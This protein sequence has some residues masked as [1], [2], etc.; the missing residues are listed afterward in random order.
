MQLLIGAFLGC[1]VGAGVWIVCGY[2]NA[3]YQPEPVSAPAEDNASP[4]RRQKGLAAPRAVLLQAAFAVLG[5]YLWW[6][7]SNP[8][9]V[10]AALVLTGLLACIS[11]VDFQVRRIPNALCLALVG[12]ALVQML[13]LGQPRPAS[14]ALGMLIAGVL[15]FV[16]AL[17]GRG[18][19]GAGD[20][21]L[22]AALG[23]ILGYPLVFSALAC[24][25]IVGGIAA[26]VLIVARRVGRKGYMAYG[27][28]LALGSWMVWMGAM[29]FW[30]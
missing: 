26:L 29:K 17:A 8:T 28:Y 21:K 3:R 23:A 20:V 9:Q 22:A 15:F 12:W 10:V 25:I 16:V 5:A 6:R 2:F 4:L 11:L 24:G 18:A 30:P 27:P 14:A 13:W 7:A 1:L 19:M